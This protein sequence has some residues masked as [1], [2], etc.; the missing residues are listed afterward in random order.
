[1]IE[2][3]L[4]DAYQAYKRVRSKALKYRTRYLWDKALALESEGGIKA[5]K[6]V[7]RL[8]R[9]EDQRKQARA[10]KKM[11]RVLQTPATIKAIAIVDGVS[12][13]VQDRGELE[14]ACQQDNIRRFS[15]ST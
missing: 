7:K 6:H 3:E 9:I 14:E 1:M 5:S 12:V 2:L 13:E 10:I 15:Q 8:L 11:R 4:D